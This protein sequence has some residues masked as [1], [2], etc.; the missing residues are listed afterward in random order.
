MDLVLKEPPKW[1]ERTWEHQKAAPSKTH[2]EW[3]TLVHRIGAQV[4]CPV[5]YVPD[6]K[7]GFLLSMA[8]GADATAAARDRDH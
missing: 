8:K 4:G 6:G 5:F 2:R 7:G 3:R 1:D